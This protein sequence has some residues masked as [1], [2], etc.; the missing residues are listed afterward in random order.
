[1]MAI[2]GIIT[3]LSPTKIYIVLRARTKPDMI[4]Q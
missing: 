3:S 2:K 4:N 1:M